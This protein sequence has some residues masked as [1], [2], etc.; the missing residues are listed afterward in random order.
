MGLN[1]I[2]AR[3]RHGQ[4]YLPLSAGCVDLLLQEVGAA[5][6]EDALR[7]PSATEGA[8]GLPG[9]GPAS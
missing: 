7:D 5:L 4:M 9:Q 8:D 1:E 3:Q 6:P 2:N